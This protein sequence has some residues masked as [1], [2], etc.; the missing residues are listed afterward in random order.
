MAPD[1]KHTLPGFDRSLEQL[2]EDIHLM[3]ALV[4][5]SLANARTGLLQ[6]DEDYCAGVIADDE[7]VDLL[8][9]A[10]DRDGTNVLIRFQPLASDFRTV[11]A[12]IKLG[13]HLDN[14][15]DQV[16]IVARR[17]RTLIQQRALQRNDPLNSLFELI[18]RSLSQALDAFHS[19]DCHRAENLR[20]QMEPLAASARE[21]LEDF[22]EAVGK[23]PQ[24]SGF[25]VSLIII[26]RSLEQIIYLIESITEDII[27][28]SEARDI[29]HAENQLATGRER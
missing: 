26:V 1:G 20:L 6:E 7:E 28:V 29:R 22:S 12:T 27:Y 23:N 17:T 15:S 9:K 13:S 3:A 2:R 11:L 16:G 5:R 24:R 14:I 19:L 8:E 25:Y 4:R 21:L 18:E 10:V